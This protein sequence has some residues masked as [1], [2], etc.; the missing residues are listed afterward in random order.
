MEAEKIICPHC[1]GAL[2][3]EQRLAAMNGG[4]WQSTNEEHEAAHE[5]YLLNSLYSPFVTIREF[6]E[7]WK[8]AQKS[9]LRE[10]EIRNFFN[11]WLALPYTDE[12]LKTDNK[13]ILACIHKDIHKGELPADMLYLCLGVDP[14]QSAT[15]WTACAVCADRIQVIDW[16]TLLAYNGEKGVSNLFD[17]LEYG[18]Q[19]IDLCFIDSG[20]ST[21]EIYAECRKQPAGFVNPCKGSHGLGSWNK[22][23]MK[24]QNLDLYTFSDY[25]L[26][27]A[28]Y[29]AHGLIA[30]GRLILPAE[31]DSDL[32]RGLSG[33]ELIKNGYGSK[34]WKPVHNDHYGD[35]IKLCLLSS[36]VFAKDARQE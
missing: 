3:D 13:E 33:Q 10:A 6:C 24:M 23:F 30:S 28:L 26:K 22:V 12:A 5:G 1:K 19:K 14:G 29:G 31:T 17:S 35:A 8:T 36:L 2:N 34:S 32:V 4:F 16:G 20:Y 7:K 25:A 21:E 18:G 27:T 11:S 15:H 9:I